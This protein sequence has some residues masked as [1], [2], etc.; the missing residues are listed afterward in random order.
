LGSPSK[1]GAAVTIRALGNKGAWDR[2]DSPDASIHI[3]YC[4]D[5]DEIEMVTLMHPN[6]VP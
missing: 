3:R 5:R 1:S 2:F 4:L 6:A